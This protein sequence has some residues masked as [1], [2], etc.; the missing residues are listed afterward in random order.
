MSARYPSAALASAAWLLLAAALGGFFGG[1]FGQLCAHPVFDGNYLWTDRDAAKVVSQID[2]YAVGTNLWK[3]AEEERA[4]RFLVRAA[5]DKA[6]Y[7]LGEPVHLFLYRRH[8]SSEFTG[9]PKSPS[10]KSAVD[11]KAA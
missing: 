5:L 10:E 11:M 4:G 8:D 6:R 3:S 7:Q 2:L 9:S 1:P